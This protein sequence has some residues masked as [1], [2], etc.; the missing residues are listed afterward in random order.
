[1]RG[2]MVRR[3][4]HIGPAVNGDV[5]S[6]G[7]IQT[8]TSSTVNIIKSR[9]APILPSPAPEDLHDLICVGFGP[10][11]I[12][13]AVA[14]H[15]L[16]EHSAVAT[17]RRPKVSF[18]E[19]Q[20]SFAWHVGMQLP[21][22]K[23]QISFVKDFA[24]QRNPRSRF[25]F[26]NYLWSKNRLAQFT[27][28]STFRPSRIEYQDYMNWCA[29][30]FRDL[31]HYG[32]EVIDVSPWPKSASSRIVD[33]FCVSTR[34]VRTGH[35]ASYRTKHVVVAAGGRPNIPAALVQ[36]YMA[37][38]YTIHSSQYMTT[39]PILL[40]F[41]DRKYRIAIVGGGQSGAEIFSHLQT[42][43]PNSR[44]SLI[45]RGSALRPSDDSPFVN[46]IFDPWQ[47][48][49]VF[50]RKSPL[51]EAS[52][53]LDKA[54]NY[55]VVRL[56][57][58]E[59]IYENLYT[60]SLLAAPGAPPQHRILRY[61]NVTGLEDNGSS[62]VVMTCQNATA[63]YEK[64]DEPVDE[65]LEF[66]AVILATGYVRDLHNRML[67]P[68]EHLLPKFSS[69]GKGESAKWS[70]D[71]HY[72]VVFPSDCVDNSQAG[73]WLQGCNEKT[74]G[75]SEVSSVLLFFVGWEEE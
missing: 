48:S 57:L 53:V 41:P 59:S 32:Q 42:A 60:Q 15:D 29:E 11:S 46:E 44:T 18:I 52:I 27:N 73:V 54:T 36:E 74:H 4:S 31:V 65:V 45:I 49:N 35:F 25:T 20:P 62:G 40:P 23:M 43:Y 58:I 26:L 16:F 8:Y 33:S 24:T 71:E 75:A 50:H 12:A 22:S 51:R 69:G 34:D 17:G 72:R 37:R 19:R 6:S 39:L 10:A 68:L 5:L 30:S 63:L 38:T 67:K 70:V 1:V 64:S 61:R 9:T 13:I 66:D 28:L 47:A 21:G 14:L 2:I 7:I 3:G 56:E 55:G